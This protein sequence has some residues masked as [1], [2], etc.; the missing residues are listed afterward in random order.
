MMLAHLVCTKL[1]L[2][3]LII[4]YFQYAVSPNETTAPEP[5]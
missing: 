3:N 2:D 1:L 4:Y 5:K